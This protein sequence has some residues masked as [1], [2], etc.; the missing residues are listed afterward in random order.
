M[1]KVSIMGS[2]V[3]YT[4]MKILYGDGSKKDEMKKFYPKS[5]KIPVERTRLTHKYN[6]KMEFKKLDLVMWVEYIYVTQCRV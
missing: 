6:I 4:V 3:T 1:Q 5:L 2:Y